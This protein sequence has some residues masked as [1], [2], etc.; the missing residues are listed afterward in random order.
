MGAPLIPA[1]RERVRA[2]IASR[3]AS[4]SESLS[5][6]DEVSDPVQLRESQR[7]AVRRARLALQRFGGVLLADDVGTGKTF[8]ALTIARAF[9]NPL[10]VAPAALREMW[11]Q[12]SAR[13]AIDIRFISVE[14]LHTVKE[15]GSHGMVIVDES[16]HLRNPATKRYRAARQLFAGKPLV[17]LSA[18]AVHNRARDLDAQIGLFLGVDAL[19]ANDEVRAQVVVRA[20]SQ[21]VGPDIDVHPPITIRDCDGVVAAIQRLPSPIMPRDGGDAPSLIR[22][23]FLRAWCSSAE[24]ALAMARRSH[25]RS[26][27][28]LDALRRGRHLNRNSLQSW[29]G[30]DGD[31]LGFTELFEVNGDCEGVDLVAAEAFVHRVAALR[32][33]IA[34]AQS[35]DDDRA[36][37]IEG[38]LDAHRGVPV[39]AC[40]QYAATIDAMWRRLRHVPGVA[41]LTAR[42]ARIASGTVPRDLVLSRFAPVAMRAP[43]PHERERVRLLLST[44]LV[45]EGLNLQDAGVVIHLDTPWTAAR[46][47]QRVGRIAR[48][49]ST[50]R[51][52]HSYSLAAPRAGGA[53]LALER[54]IARKRRIAASL[55]GGTARV[56]QLI[57]GRATSGGA[58]PELFAQIVEALRPFSHASAPCNVSI[59]CGV[60]APED[61]WLAL[62]DDEGQWRLVARVGRRSA[63]TDH[64]IILRCVEWLASGEEH[65]LPANWETMGRQA[66]Q[67]ISRERGRRMSGAFRT[68]AARAR[69]R[70]LAAVMRS[71]AMSLPHERAR[72]AAG[73]SAAETRRPSTN[74]ASLMALVVF[75]SREQ[76]DH[77]NRAPVRP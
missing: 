75:C 24:A 19:D 65:W 12:S 72:V 16:H 11:E 50:H 15:V 35:L 54:R 13:S 53:L 3:L 67:W 49:T 46:L 63:T 59:A 51:C 47:A 34:N 29:I 1:S 14:S 58:S 73:V 37:R 40:S 32:N 77:T 69:E 25:F 20:T 43:V 39:L 71:M 22:V 27:A 28:L 66:E 62:V 55:V 30:P 21:R 42:G 33:L 36:M 4:L 6:G 57:G 45:S 7:E 10:V 31:Q 17:L 44:D 26:A 74:D 64:R 8:V 52:V 5:S 60:A 48:I 23:G 9:A 68:H 76:N 61:G 18:T 41:A 38:I 56:A 2:L 70:D